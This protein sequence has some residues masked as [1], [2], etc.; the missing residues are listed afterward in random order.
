MKRFLFRRAFTMI[1]LLVVMAIIMILA[2]I[3]LP[4]L[5]AAKNQSYS[6]DCTSN[7]NN[8]GKALTQYCTTLNVNLPAPDGTAP[9]TIFSG[10]ATNLR[11]LMVD[12]GIESNSAAWY[13]KRHL[14]YSDLD[15]TK[16]AAAGRISYFYWGWMAASNGATA[17]RIDIFATNSAWRLNGYST[18]KP[19]ANVLASDPFR[20]GTKGLGPTGASTN[21]IQF[22]SGSSYEIPLTEAGSLVLISGGAVQKLGPKQP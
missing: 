5:F 20:D 6:A 10:S 3:A 17:S 16:E 9:A 11:S 19:R 13:C 14:K 8:L 7:L 4:A 2:G 18:N 1:E 21:D 15:R 12:F 22:H